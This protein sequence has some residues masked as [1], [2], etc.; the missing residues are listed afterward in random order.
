ML[1]ARVRWMDGLSSDGRPHVVGVQNSTVW[2]EDCTLVHEKVEPV[3]GE[4]SSDD[5][6]SDDPDGKDAGQ[7]ETKRST[8]RA[9][10]SMRGLL[11]SS[12][13]EEEA[14]ESKSA[15]A[16]SSLVLALPRLHGPTREAPGSS[17]GSH[18]AVK[19]GTPVV[20]VR[21]VTL[22]VPRGALVAVIGPV[23]AGKS[24]LLGGL[25]GEVKTAHGRLGVAGSVAYVTQE[26]WIR[27]DT[28]RANILCGKPYD[29]VRYAAVVKACALLPD[30]KQMPAADF[31]GACVSAICEP[32]QCLF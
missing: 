30:F 26:A 10:R 14:E 23:G 31:T 32:F 1:S 12:S 20:A 19:A 29:A 7:E 9:V 22:R 28:V 3:V 21:D 6:D 18:G 2:I 16:A 24:S 8:G 5:S 27:S 17:T 4:S 15:T 11:D 25:L 13:D